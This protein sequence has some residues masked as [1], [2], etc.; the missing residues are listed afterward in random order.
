MYIYSLHHRLP[1]KLVKL[2]WF[3]KSYLYMSLTKEN[4]MTINHESTCS[5]GVITA[6]SRNGIYI[7]TIM[8]YMIC[9]SCNLSSLTS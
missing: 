1:H 8:H 6:H 7:T 2:P 5:K 3:G 4:H 9:V